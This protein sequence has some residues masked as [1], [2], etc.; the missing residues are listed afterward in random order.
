MKALRIFL[1]VLTTILLLPFTFFSIFSARLRSTLLE[2]FGIGLPHFYRDE[3]RPLVL[4][5]VASLGEFLGL[6]PLLEKVKESGNV[7]IAITSLSDTGREAATQSGLADFVSILPF[8]NPWICSRFLNRLNPSL[9]VNTET[10]LWPSFILEL[11]EK[12]IPCIAVNAR[13]SDYSYP[14]YTFLSPL[15]KILLN[16]FLEVHVQTAKDA[17]RFRE[18]GAVQI[19]ESGTSKFDLGVNR[20]SDSGLESLAKQYG[21]DLSRP[22]FIAGSVRDREDESLIQV[23]EKAKKRHSELQFII[24]PRHPEK[25]ERVADLLSARGI[26]FNRRSKDGI[27]FQAADVFLLD[28]VGE[29]SKA[30][31]LADIAFVGGSL[32]DIG[33]HN[34]MEPAAF[35]LP[36]LMGLFT[37]T[38]ED[39]VFALKQSGGL[40]QVLDEK[41]LLK[42]LCFWVENKDQASVAGLA[43]KS[44]WQANVGA[45]A[46]LADR[47]TFLSSQLAEHQ[48][49]AQAGV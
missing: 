33:G 45:S 28:T 12:K 14:R 47:V 5:H 21:L 32:V 35:S 37:S 38:V 18:F 25:F 43:A 44:V 10:E 26:A 9:F 15:L 7:Q 4:F 31:Q 2:R 6:K 48:R 34:P 42:Q 30:Y 41:Q 46:K 40:V 3:S 39:S 36:I 20:L 27:G 16:P 13:I 19:F 1:C 8:D 22:I 49:V 17:A 29:L 23:F 11:H 24:A